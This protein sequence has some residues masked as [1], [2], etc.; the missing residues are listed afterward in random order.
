[1]INGK[2]IPCIGPCSN[3]FGG[4]TDRSLSEQAR[5]MLLPSSSLSITFDEIRPPL[6]PTVN[7]AYTHALIA[8]IRIMQVFFLIG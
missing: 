2:M 3:L 6:L 4:L 7:N 1:M 8:T 5:L